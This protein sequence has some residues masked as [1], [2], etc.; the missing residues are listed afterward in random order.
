M[1]AEDVAGILLVL[2]ARLGFDTWLHFGANRPFKFDHRLSL[3][4]SLQEGRKVLINSL[5]A[6]NLQSRLAFR[7]L[8]SVHV[9]VCVL[10]LNY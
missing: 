5:E 4:I 7:W 10:L 3:S 6:K 1:L 8:V 2:C 9:C